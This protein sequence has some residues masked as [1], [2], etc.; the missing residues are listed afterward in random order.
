MESLTVRQSSSGTPGVHRRSASP[1]A[2]QFAFS[3]SASVP[4]GMLPSLRVQSGLRDELGILQV[5]QL[6]FA[7]SSGYD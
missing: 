5:Y 4:R 1:L 2:S 7:G 3:L 6:K